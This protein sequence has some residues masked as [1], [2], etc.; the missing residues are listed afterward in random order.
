MTK[1]NKM[2]CY[3]TSD[4]K[5]KLRFMLE[6]HGGNYYITGW[7]DDGYWFRE[8]IV[9]PGGG[10]NSDNDN[11]WGSNHDNDNSWGFGSDHIGGSS[12]VSDQELIEKGQ[13]V[14]RII[15]DSIKNQTAL[16]VEK[17][18][19]SNAYKV[20]T[21][22][23][24]A[25]NIPVTQADLISKITNADPLTLKTLGKSFGG[26]LGGANAILGAVLTITDAAEANSIDEIDWWGMAAAV[27]GVAGF[28]CNFCCPPVALVFDGISIICGFISMAN[29]GS[30]DNQEY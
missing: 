22:L 11:Y 14:T 4:S 21:V 30:N 7:D 25:T 5:K 2:D 29:S 18:T 16:Y 24:N 10:S 28:V 8:F 23:N 6:R 15:T 9:T 19:D 1:T 17:S 26:M 3:P 20:A 12:N 13:Q 27:S